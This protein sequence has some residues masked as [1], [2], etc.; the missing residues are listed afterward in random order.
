MVGQPVARQGI[1][2]DG[3][4]PGLDDAGTALSWCPALSCAVL[5]LVPEY[6]FCGVDIPDAKG[7]L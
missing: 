1:L 5:G 2:T 7:V 6:L 3:V 4:I